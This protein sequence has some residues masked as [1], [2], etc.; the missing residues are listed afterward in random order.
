MRDYLSL[1]GIHPE[2]MDGCPGFDSIRYGQMGSLEE[3][4]REMAENEPGICPACGQNIPVI[5]GFEQ[6]K[7]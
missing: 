3:F 4:I 2:R 7:K 5:H 1:H 6:D